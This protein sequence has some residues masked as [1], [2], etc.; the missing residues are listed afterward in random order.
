[1]TCENPRVDCDREAEVQC[2][3]VY[4]ADSD[5]VKL[6]RQCAQMVS[7]GMKLTSFRGH[8]I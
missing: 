1:M 3:L 4:Y 2:T 6:C 5:S 7:E 8:K